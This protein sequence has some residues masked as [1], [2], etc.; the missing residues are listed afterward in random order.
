MQ[1]KSMK[2]IAFFILFLAAYSVSA[3]DLKTAGGYFDRVNSVF[4]P[5]QK[6]MWDY[7]RTVAHNKSA[8]KVESRRKELIASINTA[9]G[10]IKRLKDFEG[11]A[12][13]RDSALSYLQVCKAVIEENYSKIMEMEEIAEQSYDYMEAYILAR[14]KA[15][16]IM[17]K[18]GDNIEAAQ[19]AFA[20]S[21]DI[22]LIEAEDT[23][24]SRKLKQASRVYEHYNK[25]YL[26]F[27]KSYK[28]EA[29]LLDA[30]KKGDVNA[31]EQNKNSLLKFA[32]EGLD[33]LKDVKSFDGDGSLKVACQQMLTFYKEEAEKKFQDIIDFQM[34]KENFEK[35][36]AAVEKRPAKER[37]KEMIDAYNKAIND[38][39]N[40]INKVNQRHEELNKSRTRLLNNWN[41]AAD[42]F[43]NSHI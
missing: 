30:T 18:S 19:K 35:Q 43:T 22:N 16:D 33:S 9:I 2:L 17:E 24:I 37:T 1:T 32:T 15:G 8:R 12:S 4:G 7:T 25:V 11:D 5:I 6:D 34:K 13:L 27:F 36:K 31:M 10:S 21:H 28:Q 14:Q 23:K 26:I 41:S 29:Y 20:A 38:Y 3:Q 39:N 40:S 42:T